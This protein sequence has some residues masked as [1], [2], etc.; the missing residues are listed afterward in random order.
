MDFNFIKLGKIELICKSKKLC[1][2]VGVSIFLAVFYFLKTAVTPIKKSSEPKKIIHPT[3]SK[4]LSGAEMLSFRKIIKIITFLVIFYSSSGYAKTN[5]IKNVIGE[6]NCITQSNNGKNVIVYCNPKMDIINNN[7]NYGEK[8]TLRVFKIL[9]TADSARLEIN[10]VTEE[11]WLGSNTEYLTLHIKNVGK[12]PASRI[13]VEILYPLKSGEK[14]SK[15]MFIISPNL[16]YIKTIKDSSVYYLSSAEIPVVS[17][18]YL[19][20]KFSDIG[21]Y[22]LIGV[23]LSPNITNC[24]GSE[25]ISVFYGLHISY[26]SLYSKGSILASFYMYYSL[27]R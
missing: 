14:E 15:K 7:E 8:Y 6:K 21:S 10:S 27:I 1:F 3:S 26:D 22:R 16:P 23:G 5:K 17:I 11:K 2:V 4:T 24:P 13:N 25:C 20:S 18:P 19:E 9:D 12:L